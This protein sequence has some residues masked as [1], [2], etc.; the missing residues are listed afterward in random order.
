MVSIAS[1]VSLI[2]RTKG[3][4]ILDVENDIDKEVEIG[5]LATA[6]SIGK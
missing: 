3:I 6:L 4:V 2:Q 1:N 5:S